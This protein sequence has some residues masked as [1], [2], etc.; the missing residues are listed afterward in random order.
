[1]TTAGPSRCTVVMQKRGDQ[2]LIAQF[3]NSPTPMPRAALT[4]AT[5]PK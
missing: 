4:P 3:H 5:V 1:M 2:W